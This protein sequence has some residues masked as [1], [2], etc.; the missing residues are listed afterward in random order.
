LKKKVIL[1]LLLLFITIGCANQTLPEQVPIVN[2]EKEP[3]TAIKIPPIEKLTSEFKNRLFPQQTNFK[4]NSFDTK[5][6]LIDNLAIIASR[7]LA[8]KYVDL[9]YLEQDSGLFLVPKDLPIF[10]EKSLPYQIQV[11]SE[12][13]YTIT[14]EIY[15]KNTLTFQF[16]KK[17]DQWIINEI[18]FDYA[19][20]IDLQSILLLVNKHNY[21]AQD[22]V[23]SDL[24][25]ANIPFS[26]SGKSEKKLLRKVAAEHIEE[27]FKKARQE[28]I[29]LFGTSGYRSYETQEAIFAYNLKIYG[30]EEEANKLS[31]FPGESEHQSG[32][33]MDISSESTNY[34]LIEEFGNTL[35]GE[36][37]KNNAHNFG[38]IIRYPNGKENI[39]G[40]MYEPWHL[41]YVGKQA[42][43]IIYENNLTLEEYIASYI[44]AN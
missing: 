16:T 43:E 27:L 31:A 1:T 28:G 40:Y 33:A 30:S 9:F 35:E 24:T 8:K 18:A 42:A 13:K 26:F 37:V 3:E 21:L 38:F 34:Q 19:N 44:L 4:V 15:E 7:N 25:E 41:R 10:F 29:T 6:Q 20:L 5:E 36:W 39:T 12:N 11:A 17:N 23:P 32:L 14:Q 22:Y 2:Q